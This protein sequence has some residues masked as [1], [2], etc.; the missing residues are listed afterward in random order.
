M[1]KV[2]LGLAAL[3]V[4]LALPVF[5]QPAD[6]DPYKWCAQYGRDEGQNCGF[7]TLEQCQWTISGMGGFCVP[8]QFYTGPDNAPAG[9]PRKKH[10]D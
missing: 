4:S 5:I 10:R 3:G 8:N 1:R 2:L 6:A 9:R 7:L